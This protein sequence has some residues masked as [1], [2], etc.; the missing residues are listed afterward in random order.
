[1]IVVVTFAIHDGSA[2]RQIQVN[3]ETACTVGVREEV[4]VV[5]IRQGA[6][7]ISYFRIILFEVGVGVIQDCT[8]GQETRDGS[9]VRPIE[10][11]GQAEL[12]FDCQKPGNFFVRGGRRSGDG[13]VDQVGKVRHQAEQGR[14]GA[15]TKFTY[16]RRTSPLGFDG[17]QFVKGTAQHL[18]K[19]RETVR[20]LFVGATQGLPGDR[21]PIEGIFPILCTIRKIVAGGILDGLFLGRVVDRP[22][23]CVTVIAL[24][25]GF[26]VFVHAQLGVREHSQ[27]YAEQVA[28]A[29]EGI[30][31]LHAPDKAERHR[32]E[33]GAERR[34]FHR[35]STLC[36]TG[37]CLRGNAV[38]HDVVHGQR[39]GEF[40]RTAAV[41]GG[42][43]RRGQH[44]SQ[45]EVAGCLGG[46]VVHLEHEII[47]VGT[48]VVQRVGQ[49]V[50]LVDTTEAVAV[51]LNS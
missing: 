44:G 2:F 8:H 48:L 47:P 29:R 39:H 5:R 28:H 36:I 22:P 15:G 16:L 40:Q 9:V 37:A 20:V 38:N 23:E 10:E 43:V 26:S 18:S 42:D 12:D 25:I 33:A 34:S 51:F 4:A 50:D 27:R 45:V 24:R 30:F 49:Q 46:R 11:L 17:N 35:D 3:R 1:M 7:V 31:I 41:R 6:I 14:C 19:R 13:T 21:S 32:A